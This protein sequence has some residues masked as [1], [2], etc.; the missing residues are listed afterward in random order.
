MTPI[1]A[2]LTDLHVKTPGALAY[3][4]RVDT[5][6]ALA[7]AVA[8]VNA[9]RP[10]PDM[11]VATGDL[12]DGGTAAEYRHL[13]DLLAPLAPP[14]LLLP[15]NHDD[16]AAL[17]AAFPS[18]LYLADEGPQSHAADLGGLRLVLL[19]TTV[20]GAPHGAVDA[21]RLEWLDACLAAQ[22][23]RPTVLFLHHPPFAVGIAHMDVQNAR[24]GEALG[25]LLRRHPQV[26]HLAAGHV[27][28][29]VQTRWYGVSAS[30]AP[31][32]SHAVALDLDPAGPSAFRLE[33]PAIHLHRWF[34]DG[35][36]YGRIVTHLS[37]I[38][39]YDGPHPFH[40]AEGRLLD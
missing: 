2:Q 21:R 31:S 16:R 23:L 13:A 18:H 10:R 15:G 17:R 20:P 1:V 3:R 37:Q 40:D 26:V 27:H 5:A 39:A 22:P 4:G 7:A 33:P 36:P 35:G 30:V 11:V 32:P 25:R 6:A 34:P 38:G 24:G 12:V 19:G 29:S 8:H 9:L 14:L 28:R